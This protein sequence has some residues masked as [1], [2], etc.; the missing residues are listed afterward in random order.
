MKEDRHTFWKKVSAFKRL[1]KK[2][3][4]V[5][6][7]KPTACDFV[8]FFSKQFSHCDPQMRIT[9]ESKVLSSFIRNQ[10]QVTC[11][12]ITLVIEILRK[13]LRHLSVVNLQVLMVSPMNFINL[14]VLSLFWVSLK[15][16]SIAS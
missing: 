4:T 7:S 8:D 16:F 11:K 13:L 1:N 14:G 15:P 5:T 6:S 2:R 12:L 10:L 9:N 3:A